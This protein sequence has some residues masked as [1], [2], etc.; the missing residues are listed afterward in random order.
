MSRTAYLRD[1]TDR[2]RAITALH[3]NL[4]ILDSI[5]RVSGTGGWSLDLA[6]QKLS[7]TPQT[8]RL[9]EK[10][11]DY[12]PTLDDGVNF[13]AP[14]A[15]AVIT[16]AVADGIERGVP[17]DLEL[18]FI[19][20]T[21]RQRWVRTCG[22]VERVDGRAATL[23][24]SIRD[25]TDEH[26][27]RQ[28]LIDAHEDTRRALTTLS[29]Y[30]N[31]LDV[32]AIVSIMALDA[33][34]SFV[35]ANP[36][37]CE[38]TG[39]S[40][41]EVIGKPGAIVAS[42]EHPQVFFDAIW[43]A[44]QAGQAWRGEVCLRH[45][46]GRDI[47]LES[48]IAPMHDANG[49]PDRMVSLHYDITARRA[50]EAQ[51]ARAVL[52]QNTISDIQ[53]AFINGGSRDAFAA[54]LRGGIE[55][56]ASEYG[57]VGEVLLDDSGAP[58]LRTHA[59]T[60]IAWSPETRKF[61]DDNEAKG[62]EFRN[63]NTLFGAA[64]RDRVPVIANHASDDPRAA[65]VP[66]GHPALNA[67][68]GVPIFAHGEM[69]GVIGMANRP[70][71]YSTDLLNFLAPLFDVVGQMIHSNRQRAAREQAEAALAAEQ[72]RLRDIVEGTGLA[73]WSLNLQ[74]DE[75]WLNDQWTTILGYPMAELSTWD[76][77]AWHAKYERSDLVRLKTLG[78]SVLVGGSDQVDL[79]ARIR[80]Q[81]GHWVW[82]HLRASAARRGGEPWNI[83]LSGTAQD[84][85]ARKEL[86]A[87]RAGSARALRDAK[88]EADLRRQEEFVLAELL[89]LG[90][91]DTDK[92]TFARAVVDLT[93]QSL[94]WL[95]RASRL[96]LQALVPGAT[97]E[98]TI[99]ACHEAPHA[100]GISQHDAQQSPAEALDLEL[101]DD[102]KRVGR[103]HLRLA[104]GLRLTTR[105][106][107][108][109]ERMGSAIVVGLRQ[110]ANARNLRAAALAAQSANIAKSQFLA[111]MSHEIRTPMNGIIGMLDVL[112]QTQM[113]TAQRES[114]DIAYQSANNL[115]RILN[116]ILDFS[117]LEANQVQLECEALEPRAL[118]QSV[119]SLHA[120]LAQER[121]LNLRGQIDEAV[122]RQ[123]LG[124]ATRLRQAITNLVGNALKFTH[125]GHVSVHVQYDTER[126][127]VRVTDT[128]IGI[129]SA[130]C[131]RLFSRFA[132]ADSS[133][134]R[135][136]GGTGLGL[137][138]CSEII[139]AM[140]GEIGVDSV[141]GVGSTFWF[142]VPAAEVDERAPDDDAD[143]PDNAETSSLTHSTG[144]RPLRI[145]VADDNEVNRRIMRAFL[146]SAGH[147]ATLVENGAEALSAH[148]A[149]A[150]DIV[151]MDV[152]MPVMD[153]L[154]ATRAIRRLGPDRCDVPVIAITANAMPGDKEQYLAGGMTGY[155]AKPINRQSLYSVIAEACRN[156]NPAAVSPHVT[157]VAG[158]SAQ[159]PRT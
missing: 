24:G 72:K 115:L 66:P 143:S 60:N 97:S 12:E 113:N 84:I 157:P 27:A 108:F 93:V 31:A 23:L 58:F 50:L 39:F 44:I 17:W 125:T 14:E 79:E 146:Q 54:V 134:T 2:Q 68:L 123:V 118:L 154:T 4:Q 86:E 18:P 30:Q 37:F 131:E 81:L 141:P 109:L 45:K 13:Y 136:F 100:L 148:I 47:W 34:H 103:L 35:F 124:D 104:P 101:R 96:E 89:R 61:H 19:T 20:A 64:M 22:E 36:R 49:M 91:E 10:P 112:L 53:R 139:K 29:N 144:L 120:L 25:V 149:D 92:A 114:A 94:P 52:L 74:T 152:Q 98:T 145:L 133:I 117:R 111:T 38:V 11:V 158:D 15:Q 65:G 5:A 106:R 7:W 8:Y 105:E 153:G 127:Y 95:K 41:D 1:V 128:G 102:A 116:D 69:L 51:Q 150:F 85:S 63:L 138:I 77:N 78:R 67:F 21:G 28:Q 137:A 43:Q 46:S 147:D 62:L 9:H 73:T 71:G 32:H 6:T 119:T 126:L 42:T 129:P 26:A 55:L 33:Q 16:Q 88:E 155:L 90:M 76:S 59:I 75:M 87:A 99:S 156:S 57:F 48:T 82:V 83:V 56:S 70:G 151:L 3:K 122:P 132:Q 107:T 80:H 40:Q 142:S 110:R 159:A 130:D 121:G 135:R 140:G